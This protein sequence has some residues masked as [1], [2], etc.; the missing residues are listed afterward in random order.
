MR[1]FL[2]LAQGLETRPLVLA[3]WQQP[4]LWNQHTQRTTMPGSPVAC[5]DD[6]FLRFQPLPGVTLHGLPEVLDPHETYWYPAAQALPEAR[7]LI[8]EAMRLVQGE[9]LGRVII[10][11]LPPGGHILPHNDADANSAYYHFMHLLL[12][13]SAQTRFRCGDEVVLMLPGELWLFDNLLE[14]E[15]HNDGPEDRL[16]LIIA[17]K[18]GGRP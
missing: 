2:C 16:S 13:G 6:C 11:R 12:A 1:H 4:H 14:H 5:C 9:R 8:F 3:L 18:K 7:P 15:L 17:I 10:T